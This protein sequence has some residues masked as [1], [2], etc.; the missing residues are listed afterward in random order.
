[1]EER[2]AADGDLEALDFVLL[3]D[4]HDDRVGLLN[5]LRNL[6]A[7]ILEIRSEGALTNRVEFLVLE[8]RPNFFPTEI[9][10]DSIL[11]DLEPVLRRNG[12]NNGIAVNARPIGCRRLVEEPS[13]LGARLP[14]FRGGF[15]A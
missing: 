2:L 15:R 12:Q 10:S 1:M 11:R 13:R 3:G 4:R 6:L 9:V 5:R 14:R 7:R 8:L